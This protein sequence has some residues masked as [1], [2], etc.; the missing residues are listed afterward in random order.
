MN[1]TKL[2]SKKEVS[3]I[4][5]T[6]IKDDNGYYKVLLGGFNTFNRSGIFYRIK[7]PNDLLTNKTILN[8]RISEGT[9]RSEEEHPNYKGMSQNEIISRTIFLDAKNVCAHIKSVEF[10]DTGRCEKGWDGYN[11]TYVYGW[12]KPS[13]PH[14]PT[15]KEQLDNPDENVAFSIRSLVKQSYVGS[16]LVRD[17]IDVSTWDHVFEGGI[18]NA[19]Q[20]AAVGIESIKDDIGVCV[21]GVCK[22]ELKKYI[23]GNEHLSCEE[24]QCLLN[25]VDTI[26][27]KP[28]ILGW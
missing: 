27:I 7:N 10:V 21:D 12:V 13:G 25:I 9:L 22:N 19:N 5:N 24:G 17:V 18:A 16:T 15:L 23:A 28:T 2:V 11:I 8:R 6:I 14:G 3:N 20:W 1:V 26:D 4:D